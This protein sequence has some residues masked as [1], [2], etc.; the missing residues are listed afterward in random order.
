MIKA[1][2]QVVGNDGCCGV[3]GMGVDE[4][5]PYLKGHWEDIKTAIL[6]SHYRPQ[7]VKGIEIDKPKGGKRRLRYCIWKQWKRPKRRL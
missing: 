6:E 5:K 2:R 3:D 4:L 1:Y 7:L